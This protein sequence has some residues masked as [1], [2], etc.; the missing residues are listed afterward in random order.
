[1]PSPASLANATSNT[2]FLAFEAAAE[3]RQVIVA[4]RILQVL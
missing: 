2:A 4:R 3:R 1:M